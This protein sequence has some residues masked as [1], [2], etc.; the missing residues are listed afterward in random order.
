MDERIATD[1]P[2]RGTTLGAGATT[3]LVIGILAIANVMSN[4]VLPSQVY[5]PWNAGVAIGITLI[6][7][8]IVSD[9]QLGLG[10]WRRGFRFG[11][12]LVVVTT[13]ILL[14]G[15]AMPAVNK[16]FEDKRVS[17]GVAT[18]L[19]QAVVRIP[20]GTVLLEELA[21][22]SV[23]PG[24][25]ARRH[26]V[27]RGAIVAS[28]LFGLWHVLPALNINNVNPVARDVF[29]SGLGGKAAAVAF[30]VVG[31]MLAGLWLCLIRY[32]ARSVLAP[33]M[34]HIATNSIGFTIAWFVERT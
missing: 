23:L 3:A 10:E 13:A 22:R 30:A 26:G 27:M 32:R 16:L 19:Y 34:A 21:F 2:V 11:M 31:T 14:M 4:R 8:R 20:L 28:V 33:M 12:V 29:G 15:L 1:E 18:V 24:L 17:T 9:D 25:V 6:A 7:R 5:V